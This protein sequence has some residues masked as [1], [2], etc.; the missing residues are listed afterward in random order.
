M[1]AGQHTNE[2]Q[3]K[4]NQREGLIKLDSTC[5]TPTTLNVLSQE[6]NHMSISAQ[7]LKKVIPEMLIVLKS[8]LRSERMGERITGTISRVFCS[9]W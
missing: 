7:G 2:I 5:Y 6:K 8:L 3:I 9:H 4:K 1:I